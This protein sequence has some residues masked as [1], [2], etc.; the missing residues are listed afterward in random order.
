MVTMTIPMVCPKV[1]M[2]DTKEDATPKSAFS[3]QDIIAL[4]LGKENSEKPRPVTTKDTTTTHTGVSLPIKIKGKIPTALMAIPIDDKVNGEN[5][6]E[7]FPIWGD[8]TAII[9]A[10]KS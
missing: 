1:R 5:V 2:V 3:T 8:K 6:S 7:S 4:V 10:G 9:M